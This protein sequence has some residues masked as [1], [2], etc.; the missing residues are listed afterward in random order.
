M[1]LCNKC[2][3]AAP[4]GSDSWCIACA[5]HEQLAAELRGS[6]G[7]PG[8]RA[9]ASDLV[10]TCLRQV[11]AL[12]RLGLGLVAAGQKP[13]EPAE[14]PP[15]AKRAAGEERS[16][17]P[18][19][20]ERERS[21]APAASERER[22]KAP[23]ASE[24]EG[25]RAFVKEEPEEDDEERTSGSSRDEDEDGEEEKATTPKAKAGPPSSEH[26][27]EGGA[28]GH[29]GDREDRS[30]SRGARSELPRLRSRHRDQRRGR[31]HKSQGEGRRRRPNHRAGS[32]HQKYHKAAEDPYRRFHHRQPESFWDEDHFER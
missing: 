1:S 8:L 26:H 30:R 13:P 5:A 6:W 11:R 12:R 23:A 2:G 21:K 28:S 10:A 18:A 24:R 4:F 19:A 20:S 15:W 22:P 3:T 29:R 14:P 32:R 17:P 27:R 7:Q 9:V 31:D 16:K 25:V